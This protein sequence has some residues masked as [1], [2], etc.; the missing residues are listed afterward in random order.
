MSTDE[1]EAHRHKVT[2]AA[3]RIARISKGLLKRLSSK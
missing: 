2:A 1:A 3:V